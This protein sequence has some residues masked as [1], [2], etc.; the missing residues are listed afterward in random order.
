MEDL[1]DVLV[2][3]YFSLNLSLFVA[4]PFLSFFFRFFCFGKFL[5]TGSFIEFKNKEQLTNISKSIIKI[6]SL[7][8]KTVVGI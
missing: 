4:C 8:Q 1:A 2:Q 6:V 5:L 3:K 7:N